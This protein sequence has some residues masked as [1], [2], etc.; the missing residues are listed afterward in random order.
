MMKPPAF[1]F[2]PDDFIAGTIGMSPSERGAY[3][4]LLC[5]QWL[6]GWKPDD[7]MRLQNIVGGRDSKDVLSLFPVE[8][9]GRRRNQSIKAQREK[10]LLTPAYSGLGGFAAYQKD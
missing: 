8:D 2:Y 5:H 9:D 4:T 1:Q 3:I 10:A 6:H 7:R